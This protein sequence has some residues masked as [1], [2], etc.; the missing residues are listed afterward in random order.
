MNELRH[1]LQVIASLVTG[2]SRVLDIGCGEGDLLT[3]LVK[4]KGVDGRGIEIDAPLVYAA[5]A[6]G[7]SVVQ[8]DIEED[9]P[10]YPDNSFD[11]VVSSS[12]LQAMQDPKGMLQQMVRI[13]KK[14][15]VSVPNFGH[16]KNR[17][18]L[19]IKGKMPMT[20]KLS[21][22]WYETPNIHFCTITDFVELCNQMGLVIEKRIF[23]G[24]DGKTGL[25][26]GKGFFSNLFG[27]QGVFLI[28][29]K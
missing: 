5:I 4:E 16:W 19:G 12:T 10:H 29:E 22:T 26:H 27:E 7:L 17:L 21:Y 6:K 9:L 25:I 8:G 24:D 2:G 20:K 28:R 11:Y 23:I 3:A 14:A 18:Y 1:D 15:I 13:G